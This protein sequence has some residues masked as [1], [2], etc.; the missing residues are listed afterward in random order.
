M[1]LRKEHNGNAQLLQAPLENRKYGTLRRMCA[2]KLGW[3]LRSG[4][5]C[6]TKMSSTPKTA[7]REELRPRTSSGRAGQVNPAEVPAGFHKFINREEQWTKRRYNPIP[8]A[9][10]TDL[11][12]GTILLSSPCVSEAG[13]VHYTDVWG[14]PKTK[15]IPS[16]I[17]RAVNSGN[18]FGFFPAYAKPRNK[19]RNQHGNYRKPKLRTGRGWR[20]CSDGKGK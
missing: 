4:P 2:C 13:A 9:F 6:G 7:V 11:S 14:R 19:K 10:K 15:I 20:H 18:F 8:G 16:G 5:P 1:C 17:V 3:I 12:C